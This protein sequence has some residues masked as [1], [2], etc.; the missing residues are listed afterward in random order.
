M[1]IGL[2]GHVIAQG[3]L[4]KSASFKPLTVPIICPSSSPVTSASAKLAA[5]CEAAKTAIAL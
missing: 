1:S 5:C 4:A 2:V 3:M